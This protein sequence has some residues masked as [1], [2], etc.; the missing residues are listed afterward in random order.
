MK[1]MAEEAQQWIRESG[2]EASRSKR[3]LILLE[4]GCTETH[5]C[6]Q[7]RSWLVPSLVGH[8]L[9]PCAQVDVHAAV[10][11]HSTGEGYTHR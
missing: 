2:E 5:G 1:H 11:L 9:Y 7:G 8:I 3:P 4:V 6:M 10:M